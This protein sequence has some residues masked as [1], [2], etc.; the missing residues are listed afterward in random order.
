MKHIFLFFIL[1]AACSMPPEEIRDFNRVGNAIELRLK[2]ETQLKM[3]AYGYIGPDKFE[4]LNISLHSGFPADIPEAR[5]QMVDVVQK[6]VETVNQDTKFLTD[7]EKVPFEPRH[8]LMS[9]NF[10]ESDSGLAAA[11]IAHGKIGY[12]IDDCVTDRSIKVHYETLE[13]ALE[14]LKKQ[15]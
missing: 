5:K 7:L 8:I 9:I 2:K 10:K 1:L 13:E 15:K 12:Y 14:E 4:G 3:F 11:V 6:I